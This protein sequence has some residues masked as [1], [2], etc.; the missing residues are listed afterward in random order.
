[1]SFMPAKQH[2]D[3]ALKEPLHTY[4][5]R[6]KHMV[7]KTQ[8]RLTSSATVPGCLANTFHDTI[9]PS[10]RTGLL[11]GTTMQFVSVSRC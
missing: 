3:K 8:D 11:S 9:S 7:D 6:D 10:A 5:I 2:C 4:I 1:M